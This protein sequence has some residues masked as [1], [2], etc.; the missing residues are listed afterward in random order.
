MYT[1]S[2][3]ISEFGIHPNNFL[4]YRILTGDVSDNIDGIKGIGQKTLIKHFPEII[5]EEKI[6]IDK[7]IEKCKSSDK[8]TTYNKI[9]VGHAEGV[10]ERNNSLMN[11]SELLFSGTTKLK[12]LTMYDNNLNNLNKYK[13][14]EILG[15][16]QILNSFGNFHE[17]ILMTWTPLTKYAF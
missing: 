7:L 1:I 16:N 4:L 9:L 8:N 6:T 10:L 13:L 5:N 15:N 2:E 3:V 12:I 14:I 11:L 17:W